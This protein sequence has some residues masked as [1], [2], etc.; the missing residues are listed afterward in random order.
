DV[1]RAHTETEERLIPVP[2]RL[3]HREKPRRCANDRH[4]PEGDSFVAREWRWRCGEIHPGVWREYIGGVRTPRPHIGRPHS[5][6]TAIRPLRVNF[7]S[8]LPR[9]RLVERLAAFDELAQRLGCVEARAE[10]RR[11]LI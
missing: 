4:R 1:V 2:Q 9:I 10:L 5:T 7:R 3:R 11:Q 6:F 8:L